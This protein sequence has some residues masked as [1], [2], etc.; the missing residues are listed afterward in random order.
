VS[1]EPWR[2]G[3][4]GA[5]GENDFPL[6]GFELAGGVGYPARWEVPVDART[7]A[8]GLDKVSQQ[9][10]IA[11]SFGRSD[12]GQPVADEGLSSTSPN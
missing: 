10:Q 11:G 9:H 1:T 7:N 8:A 12:G 6:A 5:Q 4:V 2:S 3:G